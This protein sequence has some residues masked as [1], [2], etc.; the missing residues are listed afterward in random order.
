MFALNVGDT[1]CGLK[2]KDYKIL[3]ERTEG[4]SGSDIA[5][6]VRDAL[7]EPIRKVQLATHFKIVFFF[8]KISQV[9]APNRKDQSITKHYMPCSPG[10][11]GAIEMHYDA[12]SSDDLLEPDLTVGDFVRAV[13]NGRKSVNNDDLAQYTKWTAEFGQDG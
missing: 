8:A 13:Q 3:A 11:E 2:P 12:L 5:V 6:V 7:M 4:M 9:M 1:P 10:T